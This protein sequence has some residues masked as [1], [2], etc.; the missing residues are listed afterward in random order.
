MEWQDRG[1]VLAVRPH[2]E[3]AAIVT[4]LTAEHGRHAGV[5]RGGTS[6]RMRPVLQPGNLLQVRWTARLE[7]HLG[8]L[9]VE[10]LR[11]RAATLMRDRRALAA[12]S[13]ITALLDFALAERQPHPR[14]FAAT[15]ELLDLLAGA[16]GQDGDGGGDEAARWP[17]AY[18]AWELL[19]L[20]E[21][22]FGLD[23]SA[24]AVTGAR[25]GLV[26]VSPRTGR[27]V[28]ARGAGDWADRLL[29][30]PD[31]RD[32]AQALRTTGHFLEHRLAPA[33]GNRPLPAA[34]ARLAALLSRAGG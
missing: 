18:L 15:E 10:P 8:R 7:T 34:R 20:D 28:S 26:H 31:P 14:L 12:L 29:P 19:L 21:T 5:V 27:A 32:M 16:E 9:T 13:S 1:T 33:L 6:R 23:L 2:G 24:C 17:P 4:L 22:G 25:T 3:A 30:Y 11:L